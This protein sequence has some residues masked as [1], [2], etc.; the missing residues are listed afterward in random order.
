MGVEVTDVQPSEGSGSHSGVP[1]DVEDGVSE[2][3][4]FVFFAVVEDTIGFFCHEECVVDVV[5]QLHGRESDFPSDP[6]WD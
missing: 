1:E 2:C 4:V 5:A 6:G 3:C